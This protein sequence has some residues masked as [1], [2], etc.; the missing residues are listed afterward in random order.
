MAMSTL[1]KRVKAASKSLL[2]FMLRHDRYWKG[3]MLVSLIIY[4]LLTINVVIYRSR[5]TALVSH[6]LSADRISALQALSSMSSNLQLL[7]IAGY[8][9][10]GVSL[11]ALL[12]GTPSMYFSSHVKQRLLSAQ[13]DINS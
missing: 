1:Y 4:I 11:L 12:W 7:Q 5:I 9:A 3:V 6:Q 13:S 8:V 10:G 2:I